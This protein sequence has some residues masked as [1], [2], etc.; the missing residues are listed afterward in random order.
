MSSVSSLQN[1]SVGDCSRLLCTGESSSLKGVSGLG[2]FNLFASAL[3][4]PILGVNIIPLG[5][6]G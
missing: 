5:T 6:A 1:S 3:L 4:P 2:F